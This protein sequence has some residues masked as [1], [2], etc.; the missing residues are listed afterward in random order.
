MIRVGDNRCS[1]AVVIQILIQ[2]AH[3]RTVQNADRAPVQAGRIL[4]D[5]IVLVVFDKVIGLVAH[6]CVRIPDQFLSF[7][8]PGKAGK[9]IN[10][11]IQ[12]HLIEFI[13][14]AVNIGVSPA[15]IL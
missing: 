5:A 12:K 6:D 14:A 15:G 9:Q 1:D 13:E 3:H 10:L 7:L 8:P 11:A 2:H 4:R